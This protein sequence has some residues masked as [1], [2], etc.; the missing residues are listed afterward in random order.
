MFPQLVR[1]RNEC[2]GW[3]GVARY[4][5]EGGYTGARGAGGGVEGGA[6]ERERERERERE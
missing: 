4:G 6:E 5:D 3:S 1:G 2:V